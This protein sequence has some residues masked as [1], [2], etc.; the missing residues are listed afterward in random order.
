MC[1]DDELLSAYLDGELQEPWKTQVA[2]HLESCPAC[3]S[4]YA[5]LQAVDTKLQAD[6]ISDAEVKERE[7]RVLAYFEKNRF[8][9]KRKVSFFRKKV[10]VR[11]VPA[12]LSSAAAFVVVFVGAFALFG[13]NREQTQEVLPGI[14][15]PVD[16]SNVRQVSES[17]KGRLDDY[18]VDEIVDYL[19]EKGYAVQ[20]ELKTVQ[21]IR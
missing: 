7:D 1:V 9:Q 4:R 20:L 2:R 6:M 21:P 5:G 19:E 14:A 12:L 11:L 3:R 13:T 8:A 18:T 10:Q 16:S 15:L 17:V